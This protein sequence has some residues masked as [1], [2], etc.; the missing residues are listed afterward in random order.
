M[1]SGASGVAMDPS[2]E[3]RVRF[4]ERLLA[5]IRAWA[6]HAP[7]RGLALVGSYARGGAREDSDVDLIA[8]VEQ[9]H[10]FVLGD[11]LQEIDWSGLGAAPTESRPV[12]YGVTW[13]LHVL[14]ENG[15]VVEFG[16]APLSWASGRPID[17]GTRQVMSEGRRVLHDPDGLFGA[18][19]AGGASA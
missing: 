13:S 18:L 7:V 17:A 19:L 4:V 10:S 8:L 16:C 9:P 6:E 15:L 3:A 14:L 2:P 12:Q 1:R 5:T 11:W